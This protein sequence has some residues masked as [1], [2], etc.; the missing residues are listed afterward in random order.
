M[1]FHIVFLFRSLLDYFFGP[2]FFGVTV[3]HF[4]K[5]QINKYYSFMGGVFSQRF[6]QFSPKFFPF[7]RWL[8]VFLP[9]KKNA[10]TVNSFCFDREFFATWDMLGNKFTVG[11]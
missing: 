11:G 2:S 5:I 8:F 9:I 4:R 1:N 6:M 3:S 10:R 7:E